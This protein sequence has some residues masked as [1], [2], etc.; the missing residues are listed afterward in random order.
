MKNI[1]T[2][3]F[4]ILSITLNAQYYSGMIGVSPTP[5]TTND[6]VTVFDTLTIDA[7]IAGTRQIDV[8]YNND[9]IQIIEYFTP[10]CFLVGD[11]EMYR[12]I[13]LGKLPKGVYHITVEGRYIDT[14]C[15]QSTDTFINKRQADFE[16][17]NPVGIGQDN[18]SA[19]TFKWE[20][21]DNNLLSI[22]NLPIQSI[23]E[24]FDYQGKQ[25]TTQKNDNINTTIDL[26]T[27]TKGL[28]FLSIST[29]NSTEKIR[30]FKN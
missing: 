5:C 22:Y 21:H 4:T 29:I 19:L 25:V 7:S 8:R 17:F 3:V 28:Y 26:N 15:F 13:K 10:Q 12:T 2:F 1:L 9:T 20:L 30:F 6:S 14:L 23:I 24:I 11:V 18:K 27:L 16:V